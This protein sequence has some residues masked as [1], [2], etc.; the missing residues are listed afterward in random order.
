MRSKKLFL[1]VS[2]IICVLV[3]V[4]VSVLAYGSD[5]LEGV[6]YLQSEYNGWYL[7]TVGCGS[8]AFEDWKPYC[9]KGIDES[10]HTK[11]CSE[12]VYGY[13]GGVE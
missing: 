5:N 10:C 9:G 13:G 6:T 7:K 2:A 1:C 8:T 12:A 11:S 3:I 4:N